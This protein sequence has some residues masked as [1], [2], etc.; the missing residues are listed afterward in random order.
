M[1][2]PLNIIQEEMASLEM[3]L[4]RAKG[5]NNAKA[6]IGTCFLITK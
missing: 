6:N 2:T 4:K 5:V 3:E 1:N